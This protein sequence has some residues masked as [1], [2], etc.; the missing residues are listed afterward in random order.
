LKSLVQGFHHFQLKNMR[1]S[2]N[3]FASPRLAKHLMML[4]LFPLLLVMGLVNASGQ[5]GTLDTTFDTDGKN[6]TSFG[7]ANGD[8]TGTAVAIQSDGKSVLAGTVSIGVPSSGPNAFALTRYNTD[9]TLDTAGFGTAGTGGKVVTRF[10]VAPFNKSGGASA[11]AVSIRS[12]QKIVVAGIAFDNTGQYLALARY[13][14]DGTLDTTFGGGNGAVVTPINAAFAEI[15]AIAIEPE[16]NSRI[17][18]A[19]FSIDGNG[20]GDFAVSRFNSDGTLDATFGGGFVSTAFTG[21]DFANA[22][23]FQPDGNIVAA[24]QANN[25]GG[26]PYTF[27]LARYTSTGLLDGTFGSGGKVTTAIGTFS[28]QA[29][30]VTIDSS[31]R[32]IAVGA[33]AVTSSNFDFAIVRYSAGGVLDATF[34]TGGKTTTPASSGNDFANSAVVQP[35]GK[36]VVAGSAGA[37]FGVVRYTSVGTPD[38]SF[39]TGGVSIIDFGGAD[40]EGLGNSVALQ[41]DGKIVV[42]GQNSG[43]LFAIARLLGVGIPTAAGATVSGNV[44]TASGAGIQN[45]VVT[46]TN[47]ATGDTRETKTKRHGEFVFKNVRLGGYLI[48]VSAKKYTFNQPSIFVSVR[49]DVSDITFVATK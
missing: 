28:D 48:S 36:I 23:A 32:I 42:V 29:Q 41:T 2:I 34:G 39:G 8:A 25:N 19:G 10:D 49:D 3:S 9:G 6:T 13:N 24:G 4:S 30:G 16:P 14:T 47:A 12:D 35:D 44:T 1:F 7:P 33:S 38:G 22:V 37:D 20:F 17:A 45:V 46:L 11:F 26:L 5:A 31:N 21:D 43:S 27:A 15:H 40:V 18:I